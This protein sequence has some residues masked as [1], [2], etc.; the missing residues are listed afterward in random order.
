MTT[1]G[2]V[3]KQALSTADLRRGAYS[4]GMIDARW[5]SSLCSKSSTKHGSHIAPADAESTKNRRE[6]IAWPDERL[7]NPDAVVD[8][9]CF[10]AGDNVRES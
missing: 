4:V 7:S 1:T 8:A 3:F 2:Q 10:M 9:Q 5:V 6:R